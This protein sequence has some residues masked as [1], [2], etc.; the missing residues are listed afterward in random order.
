MLHSGIVN[1][2]LIPNIN[3]GIS[4]DVVQKNQKCPPFGVFEY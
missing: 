4:V 3:K 2:A 1:V